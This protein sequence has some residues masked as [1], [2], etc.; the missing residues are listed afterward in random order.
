MTSPA[1]EL[2]APSPELPAPPAVTWH[3]AAAV[4][5]PPRQR[6]FR[7][8]T[9]VLAL[10]AAVLLMLVC[11]LGA[12]VLDARST[13][14]DRAARE[15]AEDDEQAA[16][17]SGAE[18]ELADARGQLTAAEAGAADALA[19]AEQA[20]SLQQ[21]AEQAAAPSAEA[22]EEFLDLLRDDDPVFWTATDDE[23][24]DL[25]TLT[26]QYF[27]EFGNGDEVVAELGSI[28]ISFGLSSS[29]AAM[30]TSASIVVFCPQHSLE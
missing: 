5:P 14:D 3:M 29:Q 17:L 2:P 16:A 1:S 4:P 28:Y 8:L 18:Q 19:A 20:E 27:G 24:V 6:R 11:V 23:L 21:V 7:P 25:G 26:C 15:A 22:Q 9:V 30:L 10:V 13:A 12:L